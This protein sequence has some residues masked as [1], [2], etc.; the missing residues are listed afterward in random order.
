MNL[1]F[2]WSQEE[3]TN[4]FKKSGEIKEIVFD[5]PN[6]PDVPCSGRGRVE[7]YTARDAT[8]AIISNDKIDYSKE[9]GGTN[10]KKEVYVA[11]DH[12]HTVYLPEGLSGLGPWE[13]ENALGNKFIELTE[14]AISPFAPCRL[15]CWLPF[16]QDE[17][18]V[19]FNFEKIKKTRN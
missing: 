15:F 19:K 8:R 13:S 12:H 10:F 3:I 16:M 18:T 6:K 9:K 4:L 2:S 7:Y 5:A 11:V 14:N 17:E 1:F